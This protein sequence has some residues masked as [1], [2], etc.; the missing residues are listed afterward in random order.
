MVKNVNFSTIVARKRRPIGPKMLKIFAD[1][2]IVQYT[3]PTK[4]WFY[5]Y[6]MH[7]AHC[8]K[9][10]LHRRIQTHR[11]V[12]APHTYIDISICTKT[13]I[14]RC[15]RSSCDRHGYYIE[16]I[17]LGQCM[18]SMLYVRWAE[19]AVVTHLKPNI[20]PNTAHTVPKIFGFSAYKSSM[21]R[22][23]LK[24]TPG[25]C[26]QITGPETCHTVYTIASAPA[27]TG[28]VFRAEIP[29]SFRMQW[30]QSLKFVWLAEPNLL[31]PEWAKKII[32]VFECIIM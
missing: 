3:I 10:K 16:I 4:Y 11:L 26:L 19:D 25:L 15:N 31:V 14:Y 12:Y 18:N 22:L 20:M 13:G 17:F 9:N 28:S 32:T 2:C 8:P 7:I 29:L 23:E 24:H 27:V 21:P 30:T 5:M 6:C 1:P